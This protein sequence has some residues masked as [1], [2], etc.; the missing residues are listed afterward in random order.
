MQRLAEPDDVGG[1]AS[2]AQ[3]LGEV[4]LLQ[5]GWAG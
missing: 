3:R 4:A 1:L 2:L 5:G